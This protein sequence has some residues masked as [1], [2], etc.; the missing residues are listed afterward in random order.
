MLDNIQ[1]FDTDRSG[2]E[3][4]GFVPIGPLLQPD[5]ETTVVCPTI[6][7]L[8]LS[9]VAWFLAVGWV[10]LASGTAIDFAVAF[11]AAVF[12]VLFTLLL[13]TASMAI[14]KD[15]GRSLSRKVVSR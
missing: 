9:A 14:E 6:I 5:S 11:V 1:T 4:S 8:V 12:V 10:N 7:R 3:L 13:I 15:A 2:T